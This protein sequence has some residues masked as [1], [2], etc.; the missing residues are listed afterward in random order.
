MNMNG[1][2]VSW[3]SAMPVFPKHIRI[4][5]TCLRSCPVKECCH[6]LV[7]VASGQ[8]Y[9]MWPVAAGSV[10]VLIIPCMGESKFGYPL[11]VWGSII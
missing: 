1:A 11:V 3:T 8:E 2:V 4:S 9:L 10:G 6:G 7:N 5:A